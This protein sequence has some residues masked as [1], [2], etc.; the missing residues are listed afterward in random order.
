MHFSYL[1]CNKRDW[2]T[3]HINKNE[4]RYEEKALIFDKNNLVAYGFSL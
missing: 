2:N 1:F 3:T 4:Y